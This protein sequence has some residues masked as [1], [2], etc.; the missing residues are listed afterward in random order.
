MSVL[1][2]PWRGSGYYCHY[3]ASLHV[4]EARRQGVT[5]LEPVS[6]EILGPPDHT[7]D[8]VVV[9]A[10]GVFIVDLEVAGSCMVGAN[11]P[12]KESRGSSYGMSKQ[13]Y[14]FGNKNS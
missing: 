13:K 14:R 4:A 7:V 2:G 12:W 6:L 1:P 3:W 5:E 9:S 11:S 8:I 10:A